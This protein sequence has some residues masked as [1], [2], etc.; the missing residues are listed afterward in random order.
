MAPR[1][2]WRRGAICRGLGKYC[3]MCGSQRSERS[4]SVRA[5]RCKPL[6]VGIWLLST[7]FSGYD[8]HIARLQDNVLLQILPLFHFI[9][10]KGDRPLNPA[11]AS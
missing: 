6:T 5:D 1:Q 2:T 4:A 10:I 7:Q 3:R 9:V 8:H 11:V